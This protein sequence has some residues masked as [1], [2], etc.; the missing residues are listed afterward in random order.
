ML[1]GSGAP[2]FARAF[3]EDHGIGPGGAAV[4]VLVDPE[5]RAYRALALRRGVGTILDRR[6]FVAG[7][8]AFAGGFRQ[9]RTQ[10]DPLQQGGVFVVVPGDR[11]AWGYPSAFAGDHP[12]VGAVI[13]ALRVGVGYANPAYPQ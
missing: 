7:R 1:I 13:D 5:L 8:R 10:G 11:V 2:H 6:A 4:S 12:D 3:A 9:T